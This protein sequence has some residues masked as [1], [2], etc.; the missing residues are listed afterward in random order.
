[1]TM[2][3]IDTTIHMIRL[4]PKQRQFVDHIKSRF[5]IFSGSRGAG[6]TYGICVDTYKKARHPRARIGLYRMN[7]SDLIDT[8]LV[9]LL[10]GDGMMDPVIPPGTYKHNQQKHRIDINGGGTIVYG[11]FDKGIQSKQEGGTG[12]KS[13]L[14]LSA[15]NIDEAVEV[16]ESL[17]QQLDGGVRVPHP[18][19]AMQIGFACNPGHPNHYLARRFGLSLGHVCM[20]EHFAVR[21]NFYDNFML[22]P[23]FIR[24]FP[25][26]L[27]GVALKRYVWGLWVGSDG[28][29]YP[30]FSR[31]AHVMARDYEPRRTVYGIDLGT[32]DPFVVL[33]AD[34]LQDGGIHLASEYY[35][36]GH[37]ASEQVEIAAE[38]VGGSND[39]VI[40][41]NSRKDVIMDMRRAGINARPCTKGDKSI[42]R[43][44]GVVDRRLR[45]RVN[46]IP[47]LTVDPG[48]TE[49]IAEFETWE[50]EKGVNGLRDKPKDKDNHAQDAIRYLVEHVDGVG[51]SYVSEPITMSDGQPEPLTMEDMILSD[52]DIIDFDEM[53]NGDP[54]WTN[55]RNSG[56]GW[57]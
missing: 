53:R 40:V 27:S 42:M 32:N 15:A 57:I 34:I 44:V 23:R 17:V 52:D 26:S 43:G 25:K 19:V 1:M 24:S 50:Y 13:S 4:L 36:T 29:V 35:N 14:N 45:G 55:E 3:E 22:D 12:S 41:D 30:S 37:S 31:D 28:V 8:T 49:T 33:R 2:R 7:F 48:C 21:T 6:K 5:K 51:G 38:I 56:G 16:P 18:N 46:G 47:M 9:T 11:G 10:E 54:R 39:D 20:E